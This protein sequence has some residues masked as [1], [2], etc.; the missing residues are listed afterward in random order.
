M[1]KLG[2]VVAWDDPTAVAKINDPMKRAMVYFLRDFFWAWVCNYSKEVLS[3]NTGLGGDWAW[4]NNTT[5]AEQQPLYSR[6]R[7]TSW[8]FT[9]GERPDHCVETRKSAMW[10]VDTKHRRLAYEDEVP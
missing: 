4:I 9:K 1:V 5:Y 7:D 3:T 10:I 8:L 2:I 6:K